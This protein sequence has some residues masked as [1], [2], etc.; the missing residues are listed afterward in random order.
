MNS[1][2]AFADYPDLSL[3]YCVS[4]RGPRSL[5]LIHELAGTLESF[6]H[7]LPGLAADFRILRAD[8][9]GAG[10]SEKV[11]APFG[12]DDLVADTLRLLQTAGLPPPYYVAG[13]A[14]GAAIA[15]ALALR[16]PGEVAALALCA[17][18]L[19]TNPDRRHYLLERSETAKRE[20]MRAIVDMVFERTYPQHDRGDA[21]IY[22]EHR[23]R[24][25]AIDPVCYAH[26]NRMLAE[27]ALEP[28]LEQIECPCLLLAGRHDQMRPPA[29]VE[30]YAAMLRRAELA[31]IDSGHIMVVQAPDAVTAAM[32]NFFLKQ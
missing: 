21:Q 25:L 4:G 7:L 29:Q 23:A 12:L 19:G 3:H 32:W 30:R 10:L 31:I 15:A 20:G 9:R 14:S 1:R 18:S 26:A 22:S 8:Q 17:P 2:Y 24:F 16:R 5:V 13:I 6:D 27:V 28:S 11:R